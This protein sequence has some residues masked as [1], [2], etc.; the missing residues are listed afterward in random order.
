MKKLL[1]IGLTG[2]FFGSSTASAQGVF[3]NTLTGPNGVV[4]S[5]RT[6]LTTAD[7]EPLVDSLAGT[8]TGVVR[9]TAGGGLHHVL[10]GLLVD[11]DPA[12]VQHGLEIVVEGFLLGL[13]TAFGAGGNG[14][15][16]LPGVD[17]GL[18]GFTELDGDGL[19]GLPEGAPAL[20]PAQLE[21]ALSLLSL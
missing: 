18:N 16:A 10:S 5:M 3:L 20:S 13:E 12:R 7:P 9:G 19:P 4:E 8:E 14:E 15:L 1:A 17:G 21:Q 2:L 6:T 11:Q